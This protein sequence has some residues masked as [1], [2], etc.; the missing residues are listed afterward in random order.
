MEIIFYV[1]MTNDPKGRYQQHA[2]GDENKE[3]TE[4]FQRAQKWPED[5]KIDMRILDST[6][7]V[8]KAKCLEGYWIMFR[9]LEGCMLTNTSAGAY[10]HLYGAD[11]AHYERLARMLHDHFGCCTFHECVYAPQPAKQ[12]AAPVYIA[13]SSNETAPRWTRNFSTFFS[14]VFGEHRK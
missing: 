5:I 3:K 7:D 8:E 2:A 13:Q 9:T 6:L 4:I 10:C 1:G 14:D 12:D 11:E